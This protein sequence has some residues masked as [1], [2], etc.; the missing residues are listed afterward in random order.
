M[1][2]KKQQLK[3]DMKQTGYKS[4]KKYVKAVYCHSAHLTYMKST[5]CKMPDWIN[6]KLESRL[7]GDIL[8]NSDV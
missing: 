5:L 4:G 7:L 1:E 3:P 8:T 6:H 2:V